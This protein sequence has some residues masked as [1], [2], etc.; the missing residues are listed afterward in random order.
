VADRQAQDVAP[1]ESRVRDEDLAA[2]VG[3]LEERLV[4]LV[5]AVLSEAN[6]RE[7]PG[8]AQLPAR[9]VADPP[10]EQRGELDRAADA[11]LQAGAAEIGR[12]S[13]RERV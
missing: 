13:C 2:A 5:A 4:L 12:A 3:A 7:R 6:D 9:L 10:L 11:L 8:R 1:V